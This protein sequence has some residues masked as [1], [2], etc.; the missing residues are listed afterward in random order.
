MIIAVSGKGGV[1]K[2]M[3]SALLVKV[4]SEEYSDLLAI[5]ADPD[6]NLPDALGVDVDKTIGDVREEILEARNRSPGKTLHDVLEYHVL[7]TIEETDNFDLLEMGRPEGSGCYCAVNHVLREIIDKWAKGYKTVIIDTEAGL[8][9]LSRRTTQDVDI[10]IVVTDTSKRG[11]ETAKRI[12]TLASELDIEFKKLYVVI[13]RANETMV[14][15]IKKDLEKAGLEVLGAIPEDKNVLK[16]DYE[17]RA[18]SELPGDSPALK[19]V[20]SIKEK[21]TAGA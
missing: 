6:S 19:E 16:Y 8:E 3:L 17:G 15:G 10:M 5:D 1:G 20:L 2:T 11:V 7:G 12:K 9:H 21:L 18:L 14:G 4:F 13:N